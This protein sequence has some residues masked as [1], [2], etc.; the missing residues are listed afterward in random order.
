MPHIFRSGV[1]PKI[2]LIELVLGK[3]LSIDEITADCLTG[4]RPKKVNGQSIK[5]DLDND[6]ANT[7]CLQLRA[8]S[9]KY[10]LAIFMVHHSDKNAKNYRGPTEYWSSSDIQVGL[11]PKNGLIKFWMQKL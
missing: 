5:W 6:A 4:L 10:Q 8:L 3:T 1:Q 9:Q 2:Q 11:V 7:L